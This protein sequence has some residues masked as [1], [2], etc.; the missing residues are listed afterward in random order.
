MGLSE[1]IDSGGREGTTGPNRVVLRAETYG[2]FCVPRR[3][4]LGLWWYY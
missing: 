2:L 4:L 1:A 3:Q